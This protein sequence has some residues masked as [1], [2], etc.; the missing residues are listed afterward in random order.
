MKQEY[1]FLE[2]FFTFEFE[3]RKKYLELIA[4]NDPLLRNFHMSSLLYHYN[5]LYVIVD[6]KI[7]LLEASLKKNNVLYSN[8]FFFNFIYIYK[9]ELLYCNV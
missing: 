6:H 3:M 8:R 7:K 9:L 4:F 1:D 5:F 2:H